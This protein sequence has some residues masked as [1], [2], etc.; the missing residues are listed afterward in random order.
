[1]NIIGKEI[2]QNFRRGMGALL[3][4]LKL[5]IDGKTISNKVESQLEI[6]INLEGLDHLS[7]RNLS[8]H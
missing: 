2:F 5:F 6:S 7:I 1:M 3:Y 8:Q 4:P